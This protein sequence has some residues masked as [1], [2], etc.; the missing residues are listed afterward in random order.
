MMFQPSLI[1]STDSSYIDRWSK[2]GVRSP[3]YHGHSCAQC[4]IRTLAEH[5]HKHSSTISDFNLSAHYCGR[6]VHGRT[7]RPCMEGSSHIYRIVLEDQRFARGTPVSCYHFLS[8]N[9]KNLDPKKCHNEYQSGTEL[10]SR[11]SLP[12]Q[13]V[14][15]YGKVGSMQSRTVAFIY[16]HG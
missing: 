9:N 15:T 4:S 5:F 1:G 12:S 14:A 10:W 6:P 2:Q 11:P 16:L 13:W 8:T 7:C 3:R